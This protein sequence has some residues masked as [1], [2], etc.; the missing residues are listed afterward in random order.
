MEFERSF[1]HVERE[2]GVEG[3]PVRDLVEREMRI[4]EI[5]GRFEARERSWERKCFPTPPTPV[6]IGQ[7]F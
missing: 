4:S 1:S 3:L 5:L 7:I 6:G 2:R